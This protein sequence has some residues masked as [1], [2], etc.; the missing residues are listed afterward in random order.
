VDEWMRV[1]GLSSADMYFIWVDSSTCNSIDMKIIEKLSFQNGRPN[2]SHSP[3]E[4]EKASSTI[5]MSLVEWK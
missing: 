3:S 1:A 4:I 5:D 2:N